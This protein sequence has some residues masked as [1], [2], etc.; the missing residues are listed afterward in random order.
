[1]CMDSLTV[2]NAITVNCKYVLI[3]IGGKESISVAVLPHK[4]QE[5]A[6]PM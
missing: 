6:R 5:Q 1:M 3:Q 2:K 4:G